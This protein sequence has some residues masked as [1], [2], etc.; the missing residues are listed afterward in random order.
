MSESTD[1]N[2]SQGVW[3][4]SRCGLHVHFTGYIQNLR[5]GHFHTTDGPCESYPHPS[6]IEEQGLSS[7]IIYISEILFTGKPRSQ[8]LPHS[9]DL[10]LS[11]PFLSV[12]SVRRPAGPWRGP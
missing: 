11:I 5:C 8:I 10:Q 9:L 4:L 7:I 6:K 12:T 2:I 3:G 1:Y